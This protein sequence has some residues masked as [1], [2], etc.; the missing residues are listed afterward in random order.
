[1]YGQLHAQTIN[2]NDKHFFIYAVTY[3]VAPNVDEGFLKANRNSSQLSARSK[4][5]FGCLLSGNG[6]LNGGLIGQ[7][8]IGEGMKRIGRG[9][10]VPQHW[11][12][13]IE[14]NYE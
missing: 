3:K 10:N 5:H 8:L 14:G 11:T 12:G 4:G 13:E 2:L 9:D 1:M 7:R 6:A